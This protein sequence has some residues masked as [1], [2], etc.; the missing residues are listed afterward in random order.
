M[1]DLEEGYDTILNDDGDKL[2]GGQKQR[3]S[4]AR[5]LVTKSNIL[6][7]DEVTSALD[8]ENKDKLL[9]TIKQFKQSC[10]IIFITHDKS[11]EKISDEVIIL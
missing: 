9:E 5:A 3:I 8:N 1:K 4:L 7:L 11:I 2:S 6:L 10:S